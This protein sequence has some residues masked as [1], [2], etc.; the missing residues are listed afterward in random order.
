MHDHVIKWKHFPVYWPSVRG[1]HQS[2]VNPP[3][4]GEWRGALVF[5]LICDWT[6]NWANTR[7]AGDLWRHRAHH[8]VTVIDWP[9]LFM[10]Q[11]EPPIWRRTLQT[12]LDHGTFYRRSSVAARWGF[13]CSVC[14]WHELLPVR[15]SDVYD[16]DWDL[17][18]HGRQGQPQ[19]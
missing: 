3:H 11:R 5:S 8:G 12:F 18:L 10:L 14:P 9:V 4:K 13:C 19:Q 7:D 17:G 2:L 15:R 6:T 16:G 1:I